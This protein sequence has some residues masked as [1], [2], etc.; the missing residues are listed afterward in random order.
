MLKHYMLIKTERENVQKE[1]KIWIYII[2]MHIH[3]IKKWLDKTSLEKI[4]F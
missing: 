3:R 2:N 1:K 4:K